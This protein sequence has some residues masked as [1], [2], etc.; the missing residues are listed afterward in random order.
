MII[1]APEWVSGITRDNKN[2]GRCWIALREDCLVGLL[3]QIG[4][5]GVDEEGPARV[6]LREW[7]SVRQAMCLLAYPIVV[8]WQGEVLWVTL[9]FRLNEDDG[10]GDLRPIMVLD[11][12]RV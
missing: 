7:L 12:Q 10:Q 2:A 6:F 9:M 3:A 1:L 5:L 8:A 11:C 4:P